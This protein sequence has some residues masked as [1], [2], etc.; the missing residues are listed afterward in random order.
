MLSPGRLLTAAQRI[1]GGVPD[2]LARLL[3]STVMAGGTFNNFRLRHYDWF[4]SL[5]TTGKITHAYADYTW[6]QQAY[7]A[8]WTLTQS[9]TGQVTYY[10]ELLPFQS[11]S[12]ETDALTEI[13][14]TL[15][16]SLSDQGLSFSYAWIQI[17]ALHQRSGTLSVQK[18]GQYV[19]LSYDANGQLLAVSNQQTA[20]FLDQLT[21]LPALIQVYL[22]RPDL[23]GFGLKGADAS[24]THHTF[25]SLDTYRVNLQKDNQAWLMT[26][27]DNGQLVSRSFLTY[28]LL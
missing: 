25:G 7:T 3:E 9:Y 19:Y 24:L 15:Q 13:P 17:D 8:S 10:L 5:N 6:Q 16:A 11:D 18:Q 23:A 21:Q 1:E 27:S 14:E 12:Y 22:Q 2:S 4:T 26:F 28:G 20:Q